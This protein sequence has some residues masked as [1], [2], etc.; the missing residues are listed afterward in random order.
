MITMSL[1]KDETKKIAHL[2]RLSISDNE[3]DRYTQQLSN[4][5]DLI[6]QMEKINTLDIEP[7]SHAL[8]I[9]QYLREDKVTEPNYRDKYQKIAPQT[10]AGLY[11]VPQVI[12]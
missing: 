10:E 8:N 4:I 3:L 2:A 1:T 11:L 7:L 9:T 6:A 5:L 12:E